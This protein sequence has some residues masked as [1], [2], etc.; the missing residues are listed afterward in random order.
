MNVTCPELTDQ[1]TVEARVHTEV[2]RPEAMQA[3]VSKWSPKRDPDASA[4]FD[5]GETDGLDAKGYFGAVFDGRHVY[6]CPEI[7]EDGS[8]HAVVLRYDTH[9]DFKDP[10][11]YE[12]YDAR[13]AAGL[14][15]RGYYGGIF[16]GQHVYFVPRQI[17]GAAGHSR[18]LR[19][20]P[21]QPFK[22]PGAWDAHDIG[23]AHT[24]Q[25]GGSDGRYIYL[26]PGFWDPG[27]ESLQCSQVIRFDTQADFHS[28]SSY[29]R[30][31][32]DG[33]DG[34]GAAN[35][36]GAAFDGRY[37]YFVPLY[38]AIVARYDT[39]ADFEEPASWQ[40]FSAASQGMGHCVGAIFDGR[41]LYFVPYGHGTVVRFDTEGDFHSPAHWSSFEAGCVD[42]LSTWGFDGG[43]YDG[44]F[45]TFLPFI[46]YLED[47]GY[48]L[49]GNFLRYDPVAPF[50]DPDSWSARDLAQT[51]GL[52]TVGFNGGAFDGRFFYA[53]PWRSRVGRGPGNI[54]ANGRVLRVDTLGT[55]GSF[56]LRYSDYGHNGGLCAAVPGPSFL[57]NTVDGVRNV[58]AHRSLPAGR[59]VLKGVYGQG[60]IQ[61][62]I[63]G[64]LAAERE[65]E[66]Q[67]QNCDVPVTVG[68]LQDGMAQFHGAV[69]EVHITVG[70]G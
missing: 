3:L 42:G 43:F 41:H 14:D 52:Q 45:V 64:A 34:L 47:G 61:L 36:D 63:D 8:T 57:V 32:I 25:S 31:E 13:N 50:D 46:S 37:V 44:R 55:Q 59:H 10:S 27:E 54:G 20:D 15:T 23:E 68:H 7:H 26:S 53:A 21:T 35:F 49:H 38:K 16:D 66:G 19:Y 28:A 24:S 70:D 11:S 62:Y 40:A 60:K 67:I 65:A 48:V 1:I 12:A 18:L 4:A 5:A 2:S 17:D 58:A 56:S 30:A 69:E 51:D 9:A 29:A 33:V 22:A 6:F 39:A